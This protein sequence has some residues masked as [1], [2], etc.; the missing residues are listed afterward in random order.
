MSHVA[1]FELRNPEMIDPSRIGKLPV[2]EDGRK[3]VKYGRLVGFMGVEDA[4]RTR[5]GGDARGPGRAGRVR[6][7]SRPLSGNGGPRPGDEP[8]GGR[9]QGAGLGRAMNDFDILSQ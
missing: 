6:R 7:V 8:V 3:A 1:A 4:A 9:L 5:Q 2:R